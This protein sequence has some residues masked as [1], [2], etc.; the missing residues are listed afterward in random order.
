MVKQGAQKAYQAKK[1]DTTAYKLRKI[2]NAS[3]PKKERK[4]ECR[5]AL[6]IKFW[7]VNL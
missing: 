6:L 7:R 4:S 1:L 5:R 2:V 3:L